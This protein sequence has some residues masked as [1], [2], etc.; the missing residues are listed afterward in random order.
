[1]ERRLISFVAIMVISLIVFLIVRTTIFIKIVGRIV[2]RTKGI[3]DDMLF[4]HRVFHAL[5]HIVPAI[6]LYTSSGFTGDDLDLVSC[7]GKGTGTYLFG[8][9]LL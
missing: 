4:N 2:V 1:M 9:L 7:V 5:I 8:N 3:W 6:I